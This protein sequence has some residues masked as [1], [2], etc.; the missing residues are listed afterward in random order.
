MSRLTLLSLQLLVAVVAV[1]LWQFW[2]TDR[3]IHVPA[4]DIAAFE[5]AHAPLAHDAAGAAPEPVAAAGAS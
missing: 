2:R 3:E 5:R 1:A 4:E